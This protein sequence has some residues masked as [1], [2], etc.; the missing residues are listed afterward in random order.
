MKGSL[1]T[2]SRSGVTVSSPPPSM[3]IAG[4]ARWC[5]IAWRSFKKTQ[6]KHTL[7]GPRWPKLLASFPLPR[8]ILNH[9]I[10][11]NPNC[12]P[13]KTTNH[14]H[15]PLSIRNKP[16]PKLPLLTGT[17]HPNRPPSHLTKTNHRAEIST[18]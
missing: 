3:S 14:L 12:L 6:A 8:T 5:A 2:Q 9:P 15:K 11:G 4:T 7:K 17:S 13:R 18:T 16:I 10:L 1:G